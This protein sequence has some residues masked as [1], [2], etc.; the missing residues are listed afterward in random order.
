MKPTKTTADH[1]GFLDGVR[2]LAALWVLVGHCMIWSGSYWYR[3]PHPIIAVD[4]FMLVSG[5]LMVHQWTR[6][7]GIGVELPKG[8]AAEFWLRRIFRITPVFWLAL[9]A[10]VIWHRQLSD[11]M[12][13]LRAAKGDTG[14]IYD[15]ANFPMD[16]V[17]LFLRASFLFGFIPKLAASPFMGD[18][19]LALEMQF[20]AA[21]PFV[22]VA[23][24][25]WGAAVLLA[26]SLALAGVANELVILAPEFRPGAGTSLPLPI[27]LPLKLHVFVIGM[28]LAE[29][30]RQMRELPLRAFVAVVLALTVAAMQ[31]W[32]VAAVGAI[33]FLVVAGR[34]HSGRFAGRSGA[35][36]IGLLLGN[37]A[38]VCLADC[39]YA[40]YLLHSMAISL[41]GGWLWRQE[42]FL[43]WRGGVRMGV[44]CL[45]VC[46]SVYPLAWLIH[47][48]IEIPGIEAG[49]RLSKRWFPKPAAP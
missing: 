36:W 42:W 24:R 17:S 32:Q 14:V 23:L 15:P 8:A 5:Y 40:V 4:V 13:L 47:Q 2:G 29:A 20:Y 22:V 12:N 10:T 39:S 37:R 18:W 49:R 44:L 45:L 34:E 33:A 27:L 30:N 21:F 26:G 25:R 35:E 43:V 1:L 48:V 28:V 19:S 3:F 7:V 31:G 16:G 9:A 38:M 41:W 6:R 46:A 11:G